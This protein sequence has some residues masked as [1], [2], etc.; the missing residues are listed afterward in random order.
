VKWGI[1][2]WGAFAVCAVLLTGCAG[3]S[4]TSP[5]SSNV[6]FNVLV[7]GSLSTGAG[8][9]NMAVTNGMQAAALAI[10]ASGGILGHQIKFKIYDTGGNATQAVTLVTQALQSTPEG[11][12]TWNF[13]ESGASSDEQLAELPTVTKYKV[14]GIAVESSPLLGNPD[15]FP[16]HWI[17]GV[18]IKTEV[19]TISDYLKTQGYKKVG[20]FY[21]NNAVGQASD[22]VIGDALAANGITEVKVSYPATAIDLTPQMQQMQA[23]NPDA[24]LATAQSGPW[25][26]YVLKAKAALNF[27]VPFVGDATFSGADAYTIAGANLVKGVKYYTWGVNVYVPPA[28]QTQA[29]KTFIEN[30]QKIVVNYTVPLHQ[31]GAGWDAI[32]LMKIAA[33]KANSLDPDKIKAALDNNLQIPSPSPLVDGPAGWGWTPT[34]VTGHLSTPGPG[35]FIISDIGPLVDGQIKVDLS[36]VYPK[37]GS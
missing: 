36:S 22:A 37:P 4:T 14:P 35:A 30:L 5:P 15:V 10:N 16:Y 27:N 34:S 26:G 20:F 28:Q 11:G 18:N 6:P 9:A 23:L 12:G 33:E 19:K 13:I 21:Q 25:I 8:V 32:Y 17:L 2:R 7:V 31:Y 3:S 1:R 24:V 29:M